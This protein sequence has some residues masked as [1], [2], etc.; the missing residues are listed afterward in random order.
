MQ[1][2]VVHAVV[3]LGLLVPHVCILASITTHSDCATCISL[4]SKKQKML[5]ISLCEG[6]Q[7]KESEMC[8][9]TTQA[10]LDKFAELQGC[11]CSWEEDLLAQCKSKPAPHKRSTPADWQ[12]SSFREFEDAA[13]SCTHQIRFCLSDSMCNKHLAPVLQTCM[14]AQCDHDSCGQ[15]MRR[16]YSSV[17]YDLAE[18]LVMCECDPPDVSCLQMKAAIH[19]NTCGDQLWIC[20]EAVRRCLE[21]QHCRELLTSFQNKCWTSEES[22]CSE[23]TLQSECLH[24]MNP[25]L[26]L[27]RELD[28]RKAFVATLGTT[29]HHPCTCEQVHGADLY[30]CSTIHDVLH[31]RSHFNTHWM[32][33]NGP[34]TPPPISETDEGQSG[35]SGYVLYSCVAPLLVV[36]LVVTVAVFLKRR[37][38]RR[39]ETPDKSRFQPLQK[40]NGV[41]TTQ[42]FP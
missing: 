37:V 9:L 23:V 2:K 41:V 6:C 20:Q 27:G 31:N 21:E 29:L 1:T 22:S 34:S 19:G 25:A 26:I 33:D 30:T 4:L 10:V 40:S 32:R 35:L 8:N 17:P 3:F 12:S 39:N 42:D 24:L 5:F 15:E 38:V 28:C 16:F 36:I 18:R 7:I 11:V 13:R 14:E